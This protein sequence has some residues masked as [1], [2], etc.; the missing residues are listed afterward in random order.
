M[1]EKENLNTKPSSSEMIEIFSCVIVYS[2]VLSS[3]LSVCIQLIK[4]SVLDLVSLAFLLSTELFPLALWFFS[5]SLMCSLT[6]R[7]FYFFC[8]CVQAYMPLW[9]IGD[10]RRWWLEV[11]CSWRCSCPSVG[12]GSFRLCCP[13]CS[14][15]GA[16]EPVWIASQ[17]LFLQV[18]PNTDFS[19][20][21]AYCY[22]VSFFWGSHGLCRTKP[23]PF[24]QKLKIMNTVFLLRLL[25]V[26]VSSCCGTSSCHLLYCNQAA[27]A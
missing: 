4:I 3:S 11:S 13:A 2:S 7:A 23:L 24:Y 14:L 12:I 9:M 5:S 21:G 19:D 20:Q 8:A 18:T 6:H 22:V 16:V 10:C 27:L 25:G 15:P 17:G 1:V 26:L